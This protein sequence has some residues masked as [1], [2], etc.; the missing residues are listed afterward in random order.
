MEPT[1]GLA[2][3]IT[4]YGQASLN[5]TDSGARQEAYSRMWMKQHEY[6]KYLKAAGLAPDPSVLGGL[7]SQARQA[8]TSG[9]EMGPWNTYGLQSEYDKRRKE[10]DK[11]QKNQLANKQ[12]GEIRALSMPAYQQP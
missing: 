10:A 1:P 2:E 6:D 7:L 5:A 3:Q 12:A 11:W 9:K 4:A 8:E